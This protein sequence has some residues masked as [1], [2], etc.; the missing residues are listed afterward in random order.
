MRTLRD[1]HVQQWQR[2]QL[3]D[4]DDYDGEDNDDDDDTSNACIWCLV[5]DRSKVFSSKD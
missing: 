4:D 2:I 5:V 1:A 3:L